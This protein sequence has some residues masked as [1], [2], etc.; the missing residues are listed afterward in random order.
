MATAELTPDPCKIEPSLEALPPQRLSGRARVEGDRFQ[1][2]A[3]KLLRRLPKRTPREHPS[4]PA[5]RAE[6][7]PFPR[8]GDEYSRH[9]LALLAAVALVRH[10]A[11]CE[12]A[13]FEG[14]RW[15]VERCAE[16]MALPDDVVEGMPNYAAAVHAGVRE[17]GEA[18][19][20]PILWVDR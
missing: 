11:A 8:A 13:E 5:R 4:P 18:A 7:I 15:L 14:L 9:G 19:L 1:E 3:R 20:P 17:G 10:G 2:Y 16:I 12:A 6:V